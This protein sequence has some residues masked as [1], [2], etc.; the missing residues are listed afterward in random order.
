MKKSLI[1]L[2]FLTSCYGGEII[3]LPIDS[4]INSKTA[5][6]ELD[7][8]IKLNFENQEILSSST[9]LENK[10]IKGKSKRNDD[11]IEE[12][13]NKSFINALSR[14]QSYTAKKGGNKINNIHSCLYSKI[15]QNSNEFECKVNSRQS[16]VVLH[17]I[18]EK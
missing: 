3:T 7:K 10:K 18:I 17:G 5:K 13:C 4:A 12:S 1:Y 2:L 16:V 9:S 15:P 6:Y 8:N 11:T 14:F